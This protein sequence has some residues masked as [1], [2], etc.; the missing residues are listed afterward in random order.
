MQLDLLAELFPSEQDNREDWERYWED[1]AVKNWHYRKE[2]RE[3]IRKMFEEEERLREMGIK[4]FN[5]FDRC[6][7]LR[8]V[9]GMGALPG[10]QD[11]DERHLGIWDS[12]ID[13]HVVWDRCWA[14][15]HGFTKDRVSKVF[16]CEYQAA[17]ETG[18]R[19]YD[20]AGI[21]LLP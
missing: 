20:E 21:E 14:A 3:V 6:K 17:F 1:I 11:G 7:V 12:A 15:Q 4:G 19:Y 9:Y 2:A 13:Y 18:G 5:A 16:R 8:V 10:W